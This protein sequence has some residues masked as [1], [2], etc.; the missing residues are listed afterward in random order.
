VARPIG[1]TTFD[2]RPAV[3]ETGSPRGIFS[4]LRKSRTFGIEGSF[5]F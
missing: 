2:G 3:A 5:S 1:P 4:A